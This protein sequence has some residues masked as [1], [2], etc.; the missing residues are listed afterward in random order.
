MLVVCTLIVAGIVG[1]PYLSTRLSQPV[2][3]TFK[4]SVEFVAAA[5]VLGFFL[6]SFISLP[7]ALTL[8][9][10][11][12]RAR[13]IHNKLNW[14][15]SS[16]DGKKITLSPDESV[17]FARTTLVPRDRPALVEAAVFGDRTFWSKG[18]QWRASGVS[19]PVT[20]EDSSK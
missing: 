10:F 3:A 2:W 9:I 8:A 5:L 11:R 19:L 7:I 1:I 4:S 16:T 14:E 6:P 15:A 20:K 12:H 17:Q 13:A 18:F